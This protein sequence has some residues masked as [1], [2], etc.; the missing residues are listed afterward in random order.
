VLVP[1]TPV[2]EDRL[3]PTWESNVRFAG[4]IGAMKPEAET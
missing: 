2:N 4:Q 1:E 3:S